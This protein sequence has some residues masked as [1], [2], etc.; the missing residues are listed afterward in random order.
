MSWMLSAAGTSA[1]D[2]CRSSLPEHHS[3]EIESNFRNIADKTE[4]IAGKFSDA[5]VKTV[6]K[7]IVEKMKSYVTVVEEQSANDEHKSDQPAAEK[8]E[9]PKTSPENDEEESEVMKMIKED[10]ENPS[11]EIEVPE[12]LEFPDIQKKIR[13]V[14]EEA[15]ESSS[16]QHVEKKLKYE[17]P[18][19]FLRVQKNKYELRCSEM[20]KFQT[21]MTESFRGA[22]S[23]F[24]FFNG[25]FYFCNISLNW[26]FKM[27]FHEIKLSQSFRI[28]FTELFQNLI[29]NFLRAFS[30][31]LLCFH[32]VFRNFRQF[33]R[34]FSLS[35]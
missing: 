30:I 4:V 35:F 14:L 16:D 31:K 12:K 6:I 33:F 27:L 32:E 7:T 19:D 29:V 21:F 17:S 20:M 2:C 10:S 1:V 18:L 25:A 8:E 3:K 11:N 28:A 34:K 26:T 15:G 13:G 23:K 24:H 22:F 5:S 9:D